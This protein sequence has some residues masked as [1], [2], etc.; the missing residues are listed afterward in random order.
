MD[1][2]S[3]LVVLLL[4][5]AM[6]AAVESSPIHDAATITLQQPILMKDLI[7]CLV[8]LLL[9]VAVAVEATKLYDAGWGLI[10][11]YN[12]DSSLVHA[13]L[14]DVI[15]EDNGMMLDSD[16]SRRTLAGRPKYIS[17]GSL[18]RNGIPCR[19]SGVTYYNCGQ[20]AN[21]QANTYRRGCS[22]IT[23]CARFN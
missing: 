3:C 18:N 21:Q 2:K 5:L 1:F 7:L 20:P 14:G 6:V 15:G 16:S 10:A 11:R 22:C 23:R 8:T 17:D 19:R 13:S 12:H 4:A 9:A